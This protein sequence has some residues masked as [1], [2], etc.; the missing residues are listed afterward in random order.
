[1]PAATPERPHTAEPPQAPAEAL[2]APAEALPAE[3]P[4]APL[5]EVA[6]RPPNRRAIIA[7]G[8]LLLIVAAGA[9]LIFA[10]PT[11][12]GPQAAG[13]DQPPIIEAPTGPEGLAAGEPE[14]ATTEQA[15]VEE[16]PAPEPPIT[17]ASLAITLEQ[18]VLS[19][20]VAD[21]TA[22]TIT[23][24]EPL[25][26][27]DADLSD[28]GAVEYRFRNWANSGPPLQEGRAWLEFT[29]RSDAE[30]AAA[31]EPI[32]W[33][34]GDEDLDLLPGTWRCAY[35]S[36]VREAPLELFDFTLAAGGE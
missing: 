16:T 5:H 13:P 20:A 23:E 21:A 1:M 8:A 6:G 24:V 10:W 26:G 31:E 3:E 22:A 7:L 30:D 17:L 32:T 18:P 2:Q 27:F 35:N 4:A 14:A 28:V 19:L 11:L 12:R 36:H 34:A 33:R 15:P 29:L 9:A 25:P